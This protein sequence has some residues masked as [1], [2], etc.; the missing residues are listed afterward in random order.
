VCRTH[1]KPREQPLGPVVSSGVGGGPN[2][3]PP[4]LIARRGVRG[5]EVDVSLFKGREMLAVART[6]GRGQLARY[7]GHAKSATDAFEREF[8]QMVGTQHSLAV[9]SGTSA[10]MCALIGAGIGPGDEVLVPAYTWISSAAAP[11]AI[12]AVPVLVDIDDSLTIDPIDIKRKITSR[13]RAIMPVHMLNLVCDM[14]P[15]CAI[16]AEHDLVVIEDACQAIGA[17]YKGRRVGSI[18]H[19]GAFSFNQHKNI[20]AGEGGM[21]VTDDPRIIVRAGM[22]HDVGSYS[23]PTWV[24][25][26]EPLFVGMNLR[27]PELISSVL[28][29]QLARL[30]KQ[31]ARRKER[32]RMMLDALAG[33][34][35]LHV[36][37][38]HDAA[39]AIGLTV[40]FDEPEAAIAFAEPRAGVNRLIET[41]RHVYTSW[42][43]IVSKRTYSDKI[44][45]YRWAYGDGWRGDPV[46]NA[47]CPR[48]TEVLERTCSVTLDPDL[49]M[50]AFRAV[51]R[52][53]GR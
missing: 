1:A 5:R 34:P 22:F 40:Y 52:R 26:E 9:N 48:T 43:S 50:P 24:A 41:G 4:W 30:D 51:V 53:I 6:V 16:A 23:R 10:L 27:M 12:G 49:P 47:D 11:L 2:L 39:E 29:P 15:I 18:G 14:D 21:V 28:R 19:A 8:A 44:D 46:T 3:S 20:K 7:G 35:G 45:P 31:L 38:H 42:Q 37:P 36:S 33:H 17:R 32:R 13:T 25:T